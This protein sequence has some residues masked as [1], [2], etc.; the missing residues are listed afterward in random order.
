MIITKLNGGLGNQ[1]F[2]YAIG[3]ALSIKQETELKLDIRELGKNT[4]VVGDFIKRGYK[5][6]RYNITGEIASDQE[7]SSFQDNIVNRCR[8]ILSSFGFHS[9]PIYYK[10]QSKSYDANVMRIGDNV[11]LDGYWQNENY[12]SEFR[13]VILKDF[14]LRSKPNKENSKILKMINTSGSVAIHIRRTDY[15]NNAQANKYYVH[16]DLSYYYNAIEFIRNKVGLPLHFFIFSDDMLWVKNTLKL[17]EVTYCDI[18]DI[19]NAEE[20]LRLMQSCKYFIIANSSF[21]WWGAWLSTYENKIVIAPSDW[22][23]DKKINANQEI[24]P[25]NWVTL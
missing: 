3:R 13:N 8:I 20:D 24:V 17:D 2:Q 16:L 18:N 25:R 11:Y 22:F 9:Q 19:E 21:S 6:D 15:I 4:S 23:K 14:T 5:L 12:F 1:M 7:L 10:Q